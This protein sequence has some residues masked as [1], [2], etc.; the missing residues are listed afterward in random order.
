MYAPDTASTWD[1]SS[2]ESSV[3]TGELGLCTRKSFLKGDCGI[4]P[5]DNAG[6]CIFGWEQWRGNW[7][8]PHQSFTS[9]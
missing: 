9:A 6:C 8:L 3:G 5:V 2:W 7:G 4:P 1:T